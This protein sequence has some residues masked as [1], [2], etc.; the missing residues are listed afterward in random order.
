MENNYTIHQVPHGYSF[1]LGFYGRCSA[2]TECELYDINQ[3]E[4]R[5]IVDSVYQV[6]GKQS[7]TTFSWYKESLVNSGVNHFESLECGHS[8]YFVIK[9]GTS[10][11]AIKNL[12]ITNNSSSD[13]RY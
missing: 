13:L 4:F 11:L 6:D 7:G 3:P 12:Y 9:P 8:Y 1:I 10:S 5:K 2:D